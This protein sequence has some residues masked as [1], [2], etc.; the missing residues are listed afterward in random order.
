MKNNQYKNKKIKHQPFSKAPDENQNPNDNKSFNT[1][2]IYK[3]KE[4]LIFVN[5]N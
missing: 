3:E 2:V 5:K 4:I 1:A